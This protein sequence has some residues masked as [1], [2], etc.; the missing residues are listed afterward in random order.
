MR[1][2][3]WSMS[4]IIIGLLILGLLM[5]NWL[6][7]ASYAGKMYW[8]HKSFG[9]LALLL[10][11]VRLCLR[12]QYRAQIP[13]LPIDMPALER[14]AAHGGHTL[15]YVLM[16]I[17][18]I[19][20]YLMSSTYTASS[21]ITFFGLALPDVLPKND[22]QAQ[23]FTAVHVISAY[24]IGIMVLLHVAAV[25]KHRFFDSPEHDSLRKML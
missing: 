9:V 16:L 1:I 6:A 14:K 10:I 17:V 20:G 3:H 12:W 13:Q 5:A 7:D 25:I 21:G 24:T 2:M 15:L 22:V 18:P 19:S 11:F 8:W 4:L 23:F